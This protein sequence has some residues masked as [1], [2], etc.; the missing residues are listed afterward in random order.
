MENS[1]S[2]YLLDMETLK[3]FPRRLEWLHMMEAGESLHLQIEE[4]QPENKTLHSTQAAITEQMRMKTL[5]WAQATS[6]VF[7]SSRHC[8]KPHHYHT[9]EWK[10]K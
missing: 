5:K 7:S 1:L 4:K 10:R 6:L 9:P 8:T 3:S 2:I